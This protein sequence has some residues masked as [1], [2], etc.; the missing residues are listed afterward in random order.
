MHSLTPPAHLDLPAFDAF[1]RADRRIETA[2]GISDVDRVFLR[3][4]RRE[5]ADHLEAASMSERIDDL[6]G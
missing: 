2:D 6:F 3:K 5:L 4:R 1:G